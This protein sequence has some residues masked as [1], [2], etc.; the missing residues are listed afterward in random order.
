M[1]VFSTNL[2]VPY[3]PMISLSILQKFCLRNGQFLPIHEKFSPSKVSCYT[4]CRNIWK[5]AWL[6]V[7]Q[8][9]IDSQ[10]SELFAYPNAQSLML[11]KRFQI[12]KVG[13]VCRT[14]NSSYNLTNSSLVTVH[15]QYLLAL[16]LCM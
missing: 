6:T 10:L 13:L 2:V 15:Y 12:V 1:K 5:W 9:I 4:V 11:A 8:I 3:S 14:S 7:H 16:T